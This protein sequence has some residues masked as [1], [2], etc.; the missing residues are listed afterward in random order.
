MD[1]RDLAWTLAFGAC[2]GGNGTLVGA[3][4]NL[5]TAGISTSKGYPITFRSFFKFG[6]TS[7]LITLLVSTVYVLIRYVK[8]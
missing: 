8:F 2:F 7:T 1:I 6:A 4:A 3:G 5:V